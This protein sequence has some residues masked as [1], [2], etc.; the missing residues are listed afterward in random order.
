MDSRFRGND[1]DTSHLRPAI[2]MPSELTHREL[3]L[4]PAD[5]A[6][7]ANLNGPLDEHLRQLELRLGVEIGNRRAAELRR[8]SV[9]E[10]QC[11]CAARDARRASRAERDRKQDGGR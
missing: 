7:L 11:V 9:L 5:H 4:E 3:V 10:D 2:R 8:N 1:A 6:R